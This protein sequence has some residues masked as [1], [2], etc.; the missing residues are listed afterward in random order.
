MVGADDPDRDAV[1]G[2]T[3]QAE[4]LLGA[5]NQTVD[6]VLSLDLEALQEPMFVL[7]P[8]RVDHWRFFDWLMLVEQVTQTGRFLLV[9]VSTGCRTGRCRLLT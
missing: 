2:F 5:D 9:G 6:D 8:V 3:L 7:D 1:E 4:K